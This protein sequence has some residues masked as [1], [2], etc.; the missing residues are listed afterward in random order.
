LKLRLTYQAGGTLLHRVHPVLK[1]MLLISLT[2][3]VFVSRNLFFQGSL[4]LVLIVSFNLLGI[5][6]WKLRG[7]KALGVTALAIALLQIVFINAG[8]VLLGLGPLMVT[9]SGLERGLYLGSRFLVVVLS[10]YLFVLTTS[11]NDLAYALMQIGLPYRLGFTLVTA[12]RLIPIFE[13]EALTVYRAQLVR[14]MSYQQG[15]I[16]N[17]IHYLRSLLLPMLV[18]TMSKVDA[19]AV[20]MEGRC[21][22]KHPT[23]TYFRVRH[24]SGLDFL[25]VVGWLM[26]TIGLIFLT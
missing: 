5:Q 10:S 21:F 24:F 13:K 2:A 17:L 25:V 4:L 22:G 18:S 26:L 9:T 14:G 16:R 7:G 19:L 1:L 11:P 3:L 23:R 12:L 6:P 20:S 8:Q 15:G